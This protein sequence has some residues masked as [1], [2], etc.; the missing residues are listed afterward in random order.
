MPRDVAFSAERS[1]SQ[2]PCTPRTIWPDQ[3]PC[4]IAQSAWRALKR[5]QH[6]ARQIEKQRDAQEAHQHREPDIEALADARHLVVAVDVLGGAGKAQNR[7]DDHG[8]TNGDESEPG[9]I[10]EK[11]SMRTGLPLRNL[12]RHDLEKQIETL[13]HEAEGH[14]RDGGADPGEKGSLVGGVVTVTLDHWIVPMRWRATIA[15]R[16]PVRLP[17]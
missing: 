5:R 3:I 4:S 17:I 6:R 16:Q 11:L 10:G 13:D 1:G 7:N 2:A 15:L 9:D 14:H 8:D 12:R